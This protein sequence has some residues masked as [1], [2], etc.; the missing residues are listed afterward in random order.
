MKCFDIIVVPM[1]V[2]IVSAIAMA[3]R[4]WS[5]PHPL[6]R[7]HYSEVHTYVRTLGEV[8]SFSRRLMLDSH[9]CPVI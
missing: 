8:P 2:A 6:I 9:A 3:A 1:P 7:L 4:Q 5:I